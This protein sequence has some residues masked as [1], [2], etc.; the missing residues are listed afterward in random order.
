MYLAVQKIEGQIL[1]LLQSV[2]EEKNDDDKDET[3]SGNRRF[4]YVAGKTAV[5]LQ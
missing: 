3:L 1:D 5:S 4:P 2:A